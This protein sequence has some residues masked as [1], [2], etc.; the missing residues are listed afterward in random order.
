MAYEFRGELFDD[1]AYFDAVNELFDCE[2]TPLRPY[3]EDQA[4]EDDD[5]DGCRFLYSYF[6]YATPPLLDGNEAAAQPAE[7]AA[8]AKEAAKA[9]AGKAEAEEEAEMSAFVQE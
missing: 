3:E 2:T 1:M 9:C 4:Y 7:G 8:G 6:P 5:E